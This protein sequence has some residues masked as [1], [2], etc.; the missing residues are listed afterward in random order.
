MYWYIK[1][2]ILYSPVTQVPTFGMHYNYLQVP[3]C[4]T[5][6][7]PKR[8]TLFFY[9]TI[10]TQPS[11]VNQPKASTQIICYPVSNKQD[12][13]ASYINF[14]QLH[15]IKTNKQIMSISVNQFQINE[16]VKQTILF[17]QL[18]INKTNRQTISIFVH[19][20]QISETNHASYIK[21]CSPDPPIV[22]ILPLAFSW[23][24]APKRGYSSLYGL[25]F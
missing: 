5:A 11:I 1:H 6:C 8:R 23:R 13:Q 14:H 2:N 21:I 25:V 17:F 22:I 9:K 18:H 16:T 10:H 20:H 3:S 19:Q 15:I 7:A 12:N 24:L 4:S